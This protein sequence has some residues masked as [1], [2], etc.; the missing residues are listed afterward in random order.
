MRR[1][2]NIAI[3][4]GNDYLM[5]R[6]I[7]AG[8]PH[9]L[10]ETLEQLAQDPAWNVRSSCARN[11]RCP[12]PAMATLAQDPQWEVRYS[13]ATNPACPP[14]IQQ[15]LAGDLEPQVID[16][17]LQ[18]PNLA[19]EALRALAANTQ[20]GHPHAGLRLS[21]EHPRCP[22]DVLQQAA[23]TGDPRLLQQVAQHTQCPTQLRA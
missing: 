13:L 17:L 1:A 11:P 5:D 18:H 7:L 9:T 8:H 14:H 3:S 10:P 19:P 4:L 12:Q 6:Q 16:K 2:T 23:E 21:V 15:I 20:I 22:P